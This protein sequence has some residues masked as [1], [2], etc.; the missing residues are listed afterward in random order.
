MLT[1]SVS[2]PKRTTPSFNSPRGA[3]VNRETG[4]A[5]LG[6]ESPGELRQFVPGELE[7]LAAG[8]G[9]NKVSPS[10]NALAEEAG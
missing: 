8:M 1:R 10:Q 6:G 3:R 9:L 4:S 2:W 5:C 7:G